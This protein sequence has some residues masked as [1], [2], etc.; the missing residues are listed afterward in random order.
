MVYNLSNLFHECATRSKRVGA[1]KPL[2]SDSYSLVWDAVTAWIESQ[3]T[4][5]RGASLHG[6][7]TVTYRKMAHSM[8]TSTSLQPVFLL[9]EN[10]SR[11]SMMATRRSAPTI[12]ELTINEEM[13]FSKLSLMYV[14]EPLKKDTIASCWKNMVARIGEVMK[15]GIEMRLDFGIGTMIAKDNKVDFNFSGQFCGVTMNNNNNSSSSSGSENTSSKANVSK[16][17]KNL[18]MMEG[19]SKPKKEMDIFVN[20]SNATTTS[21]RGA[22][23]DEAGSRPESSKSTS[24]RK[25]SRASS[26]TQANGDEQNMITIQKKKL[27]ARACALSDAE[28]RQKVEEARMKREDERIERDMRN[29][30]AEGNAKAEGIYKESVQREH[31]LGQFLKKQIAEKQVCTFSSL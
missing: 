17:V 8:P 26:I 12:K 15:A 1:T 13:N 31:D 16:S 28:T 6:F 9:H 24:T 25:S 4:S 5:K 20:S 7:A 2:E 23:G 11:S 30:L 10:F 14:K 19:K 22:P 3:L 18:S 21:G 27:T 29:Q